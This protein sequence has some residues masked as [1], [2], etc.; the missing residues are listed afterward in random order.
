MEHQMEESENAKLA[1]NLRAPLKTHESEE[2]R[3]LRL[4]EEMKLKAREKLE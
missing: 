3:K 4:K 2:I 1:E